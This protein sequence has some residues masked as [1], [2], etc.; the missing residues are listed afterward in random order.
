MFDLNGMTVATV[1]GGR[2]WQ[3]CSIQYGARGKSRGGNA[4]MPFLAGLKGDQEK[5]RQLRLEA[6]LLKLLR[7][8]V[9]LGRTL[10]LAI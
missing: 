10:G 9:G 4:K 8:P 5:A 7:P 6:R 3:D 1:E 2:V